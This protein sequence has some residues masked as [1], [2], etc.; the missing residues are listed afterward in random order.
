[1]SPCQGSESLRTR[2][3]AWDKGYED[4]GYEA[5]ST[6]HSMG[7]G[8]LVAAQAATG[9]PMCGRQ[10][11]GAVEQDLL[12]LAVVR[13]ILGGPLRGD[14]SGIQSRESVYRMPHSNQGRLVTQ[15]V[16]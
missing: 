15:S 5:M 7:A 8:Q 16:T 6:N 9:R 14:E 11:L 2:N 10:P 4:K 12:Q 3:Y 1:M 13:L